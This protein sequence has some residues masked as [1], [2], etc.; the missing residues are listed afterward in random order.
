MGWGGVGWGGVGGVEWGGVGWGG[1]Q[2]LQPVHPLAG[3]GWA[4]PSRQPT[5]HTPNAGGGCQH[6]DTPELHM[7]CR[8]LCGLCGMH[9]DMDCSPVTC[10]VVVLV[11]VVAASRDGAACSTMQGVGACPTA[12]SQQV[13][14]VRTAGHCLRCHR[15]GRS[16]HA[17]A[18]DHASCG[19]WVHVAGTSAAPRAPA[20]A[21]AGRLCA[22]MRQGA[23][24]HMHQRACPMLAHAGW[25]GAVRTWRQEPT[26]RSGRIRL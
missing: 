24:T 1:G 8:Y 26:M 21:R 18:M 17:T 7:V 25:C 22:G 16:M 20:A 11:V 9:M 6:M 3:P 5:N 4:R 23:R 13:A 14:T 15:G 12:P 10:V 19:V 2:A